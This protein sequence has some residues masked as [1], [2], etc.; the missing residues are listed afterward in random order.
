MHISR[1]YIS[2]SNHNIT[3]HFYSGEHL[4]YLHLYTLILCAIAVASA[5]S[6]HITKTNRYSLYQRPNSQQKDI[7]FIIHYIEEPV[8]SHTH[9]DRNK[10][11]PSL[12]RDRFQSFGTLYLDIIYWMFLFQSFVT[13]YSTITKFLFY[14]K[15]LVVL[16]HTV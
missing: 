9:L 1:L 11:G 12:R 6:R 15:Q 13:I 14:T 2:L 16:S 10:K 3:I 5:A 7:N 8:I 4:L